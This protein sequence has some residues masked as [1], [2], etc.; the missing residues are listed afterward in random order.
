KGL[1]TT[2]LG[3]DALLP[4]LEEDRIRIAVDATRAKYHP[5]HSATLA[6]RGVKVLDLT[7]A[8][9]GPYC[10]PSVNLHEH[11]DVSNV[12]MV[13]CGGQATIPMVEGGSPVQTVT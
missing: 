5:D 3:L 7:P 12:N 1:R 8:A 2:H 10:I 11:A 9:I 4:F 6:A 13:S